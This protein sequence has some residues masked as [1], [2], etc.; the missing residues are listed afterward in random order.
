MKSVVI[1]LSFM[2]AS[3]QIAVYGSEITDECLGC[4]CQASSGC[5]KDQGECKRRWN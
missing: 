4:I 5:N 1:I 2:V 3:F